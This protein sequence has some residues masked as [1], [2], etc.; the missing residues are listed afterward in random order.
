M[1][2]EESG[3]LLVQQNRWAL[4]GCLKRGEDPQ[5]EIVE[6]GGAVS[7]LTGLHQVLENLF[8]TVWCVTQA[9]ENLYK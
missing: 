1:L 3:E 5:T 6:G 7:K 2:W 4:G 8:G 9:L